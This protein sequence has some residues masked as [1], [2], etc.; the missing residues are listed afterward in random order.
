M[1][2]TYPLLMMAGEGVSASLFPYINSYTVAALVVGPVIYLAVVFGLLRARWPSR[3]NVHIALV[4]LIVLYWSIGSYGYAHWL[5]GGPRDGL[6]R[7]PHWALIASTLDHWRGESRAALDAT[8]PASY[9]EDFLTFDQR[10]VRDRN[11]SRS[12]VIK[13]VI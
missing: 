10:L 13:N 12:P 5:A 11:P 3:R 9:Q 8:A 1:A 6:A 7:N 2:L 4:M